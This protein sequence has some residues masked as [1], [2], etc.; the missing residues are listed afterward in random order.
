MYKFPIEIWLQIFQLACTDGGS[1]GRAISR[2]SRFFH[3]V[4]KEVRLQSITVVGVPQ[5]VACALML[6]RTPPNF[7]RVRH[8]FV[9]NCLETPF[10]RTRTFPTSSRGFWEIDT[11]ACEAFIQILKLVAPTLQTFY[12]VS[13]IPRTCILLPVSLPKVVQM[14]LQGPIPPANHPRCETHAFPS[15]RRLQLLSFTDYPMDIF[16]SITLRAPSLTHLYLS[17]THA[18]RHLHSDLTQALTNTSPHTSS[19][20][21]PFGIF[22][23]TL[24][25]IYIHPG[26]SPM[27]GQGVW[28]NFAH[29]FMMKNFADVANFD[30]RVVIVEATPVC[31]HHEAMAKWLQGDSDFFPLV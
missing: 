17:L 6:E 29:Q 4:S 11:G 1:T 22:P 23:T 20:T 21:L 25:R 8:L 16:E 9:S 3:E 2:V 28:V 31:K 7:R 14:T 26:P 24:K 27:I 13:N 18:S 10:R 19:D 5:I 15:L 30:Q 12:L